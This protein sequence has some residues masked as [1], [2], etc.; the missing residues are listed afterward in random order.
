MKL[1]KLNLSLK[2]LELKQKLS[3]LTSFLCLNFF[4]ILKNIIDKKNKNVIIILSMMMNL[5]I[6]I[7]FTL[8]FGIM[9]QKN[10]QSLM[11]NYILRRKTYSDKQLYSLMIMRCIFTVIASEKPLMIWALSGQYH[12]VKTCVKSLTMIINVFKIHFVIINCEFF[13]CFF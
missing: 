7:Q 9:I 11:Q 3:N 12:F 4:G 8:C 1:M 13:F 10:L 2:K 5:V 6:K